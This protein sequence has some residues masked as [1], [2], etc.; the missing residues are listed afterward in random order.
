MVPVKFS[1]GRVLIKC[2]CSATVEA[3]AGDSN[4]FESIALDAAALNDIASTNPFFIS[5]RVTS[6][7]TFT[8][9]AAS[10]LLFGASQ[11]NAE[12]VLT[13][14]AVPGPI[15]GAGLPGLILASGGLLGW[16]RR[17]QLESTQQSV[18][19]DFREAR[20]AALLLDDAERK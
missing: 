10:Q 20:P 11:G 19:A 4:L 9:F 8:G 14:A 12:L 15:A 6:A 18:R 13:T 17:R 5:G 1:L 2:D 3:C 7:T 16:W